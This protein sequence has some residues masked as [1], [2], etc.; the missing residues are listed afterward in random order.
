MRFNVS[1]VSDHRGVKP[2]VAGAVRDD[3][4]EW[5]VEVPDLEALLAMQESEDDLILYSGHQL[6]VYDGYIE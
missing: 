4:G 2:P 1:R 3:D 6:V 5:W